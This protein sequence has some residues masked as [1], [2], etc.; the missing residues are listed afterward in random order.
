MKSSA[1]GFF[2]EQIYRFLFKK[3]LMDYLLVKKLYNEWV[4]NGNLGAL[5]SFYNY[6]YLQN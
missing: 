1:V 2:A 5:N 4:S 6:A 3:K